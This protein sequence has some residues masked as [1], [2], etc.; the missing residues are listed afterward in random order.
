MNNHGMIRGIVK[1]PAAPADV[2][3][4]LLSE[5]ASDVWQT[6]AWRSLPDRV[7]DAIVTSPH[8]TLRAAFAENKDASGDRR[9]RLVNDPDPT[10]RAAVATGP[11][12]F[13]SPVDPLP[14]WAQRALLRDGDAQ[15]RSRAEESLLPSPALAELASDA[16]PRRR[17]AACRAWEHLDPERRGLLLADAEP[18]VRAEAAKR[19]SGHDAD[20]TERYLLLTD[21]VPVRRAQVLARAALHP[22]T[23]RRLAETGDVHERAAVAGNPA[24]ALD[25]ARLLADDPEHAV[26][27]QFAARPD[28]TE[29][30]RAEIDYR[31]SES[32]RL[33]AVPWVLDATDAEVLRRCATSANT[34]L[35]RS[36]ACNGQLP[37][38]VV[39][40]LGRDD[41]LPVRILLCE[42]QPTVDGE[43]V[44]DVFCR[45]TSPL[46]GMLLDH[47]SFPRAGLARRFGD[48]PEPAR[49]HLATHD[50]GAPA[51]LLL[52]LSHDPDVR[53]RRALASHPDL[54]Y[55]RV[56]EL[57]GDGDAQTSIR[58]AANPALPPPLMHRLLDSAGIPRRAG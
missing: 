23:A 11:Q 31:V 9:A 19:A 58:A 36:A 49:R 13:R 16:D 6:L 22:A 4:R 55:G 25:T 57:L 51:E 12:W 40:L 29:A 30:Q 52:R 53:F 28:L 24:V 20:A 21:D 48:D 37:R 42:N 54:P 26:R 39:D 46:K 45:W 34:L 14:E 43:V 27:L 47:P 32:D 35:R 50:P 41:D 33:G 38:D 44:L 1:N 56:T 5:E 10:V 2:L 7:V 18:S 15:V 8:V 3:L 17:R